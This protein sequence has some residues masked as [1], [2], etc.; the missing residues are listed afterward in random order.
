MQHSSKTSR[1][2]HKIVV[3]TSR[4]TAATSKQNHC[5]MQTTRSPP[6]W[7]SS[8][9]IHGRGRC[10]SSMLARLISSRG[11]AAASYRSRPGEA[12]PPAAQLT[13][14]LAAAKR[15]SSSHSRLRMAWRRGGGGAVGTPLA[16]GTGAKS[17]GWGVRRSKRGLTPAGRARPAEVVRSSQMSSGG[18]RERGAA[19]GERQEGGGRG[20]QRGAGGASWGEMSEGSFAFLSLGLITSHV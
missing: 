6:P 3:E 13:L 20:A 14:A 12:D 7:G 16:T 1:K 19:P 5:N 8:L 10:R 18:Q 4:I 17:R 15:R 2:S 11:R 9:G